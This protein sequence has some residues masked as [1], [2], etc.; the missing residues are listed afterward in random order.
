MKLK[1]LADQAKQVTS[2]YC[3]K[4]N[5]EE[6]NEW[7]LLK[8]QEELGELAQSYL[9]LSGKTRTKEYNMDELKNQFE[10]EV[11][12]LLCVTLALA[13]KNNID[14]E[15]VIEEKWLQWLP[16]EED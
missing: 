5:I 6:N 9:Q 13:K 14:L 16:R 10:A 7:Y 12:D 4:F 3:K 15:K 8:L 1:Y 2:Q 11:V